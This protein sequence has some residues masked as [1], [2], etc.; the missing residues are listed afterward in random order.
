MRNFTNSS[1][2]NKGNGL[3]AFELM[4]I[5]L[6]KVWNEVFRV[7]KEGGIACINIGDATRTINK[8]FQLYSNHSRIINHCTKIG[9]S[10]LPM[11]LWRKQTNA[12]NKFMG[13]GMLPVCIRNSMEWQADVYLQTSE[14]IVLAPFI[15]VT[16]KY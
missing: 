12:P 2:A 16:R 15:F 10:A 9:F 6:D 7:L 5:E 14:G 4:H 8:N 13:S 1:K 11:I 3:F